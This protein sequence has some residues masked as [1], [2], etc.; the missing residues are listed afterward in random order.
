MNPPSRADA[1]SLD[2]DD[3]LAPL[4]M[5]FARPPGGLRYLDGHSLGPLPLA[6]I[7]AVQRTVAEEWGAGLVESWEQWIDLPQRAGARIAPLIGASPDE[8][9]LADSTSINLYKLAA[10]AVAG[11]PKR[12]VIVTDSGNFPTDRYVLEG[13]ADAGG[14]RVRIVES[15]PVDGVTPEAAAAAIDEDVSVVSFSLVSYRSS[16]LADMAAVNEIARSAGALTLWD[17]SHAVGAVPIDLTRAGTDLAVG[18]TYKYL[19]GGPGAPAFLFVRRALRGA[20]RPPVWGWFGHRDQFAFDAD[21]SPARGIERYLVGTPP[22]VSVAAALAGIDLI[23]E[24]GIDAVRRKN[25][26]ATA[27]MIDLY[28]EW[29]A[30][31]G[32]RLGTPRDPQRRGSHVAFTHPD[33]LAVTQHLRAAH[34][35]V[36]DFRAPSTIRAAVAAPYTSF[37]EVWDAMAALRDTIAGPEQLTGPAEPKVT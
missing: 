9:T 10:A 7:E 31:L 4:R 32:V 23:A 26:R 27:M 18:C 19:C 12:P 17:L 2:R 13:L 37:T 15:H 29:L 25:T 14:R 30:P 20:L 24:A 6:A 8:V 33:G 11:F 28:D 3:P 34:R 5:R 16:A 36:T 35:V 1:E 22:I 21:F